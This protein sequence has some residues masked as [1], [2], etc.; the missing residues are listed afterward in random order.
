MRRS[1]RLAS[2][3][4]LLGLAA[5]AQEVPPPATMSEIPV[6]APVTPVSALVIGIP[7]AA[8]VPYSLTAELTRG[9][10]AVCAPR[11]GTVLDPVGEGRF[12]LVL[13]PP[14]LLV[15]RES[16]LRQTV[17]GPPGAPELALDGANN[18]RC[19]YLFRAG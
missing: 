5:C 1:H 4:A 19:D 9:A 18:G 11:L 17:A 7:G 2:A 15:T 14:G 16:V 13:E 12:L 3:L 8:P 6:R 10:E